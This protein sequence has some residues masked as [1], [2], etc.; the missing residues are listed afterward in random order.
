MTSDSKAKQ[1]VTAAP[2]EK[3]EVI[4]AYNRDLSKIG[5]W[6]ELPA[7]EA[8]NLVRNGR[9]RYPTDDD[10]VQRD[11]KAEA[12]KLEAEAA[13]PKPVDVGGG[14]ARPARLDEASGFGHGTPGS[15]GKR[16]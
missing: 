11:A 6:D 14:V 12:K 2:E 10:F 9:V 16:P 7:G 8:R 3:V 5:A 1:P 4:W 15:R 13:A